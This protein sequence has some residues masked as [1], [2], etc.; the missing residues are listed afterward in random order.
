VNSLIFRLVHGAQG[1]LG[2]VTLTSDIDLKVANVDDIRADTVKVINETHTD[3]ATNN[4]N[5]G[6]SS[7][8]LG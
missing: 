1:S 8:S 7:E 3:S 5:L 2:R 6:M 4:N